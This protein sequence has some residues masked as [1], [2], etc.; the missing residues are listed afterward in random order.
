VEEG[1][2]FIPLLL[3][4]V[5]AF[6]VPLV[7]G[8]IKWLPVVVGEILA[9]VLIGYSGLNLVGESQILEFM[10]D[11]GLAFLMFIAGMEINLNK[12]L[13]IN[14]N[15]PSQQDRKLFLPTLG[16]YLLTVSLAIPGGFLLN[17][18]GL[19]DIFGCL[20]PDPQEARDDQYTRWAV[21]LLFGHA[22]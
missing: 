4:L 7:V 16:V 15:T 8:R 17:R 11:I 19:C 3:I 21:D 13:P 18:L 12:L 22:G 10:G 14:G 2:N 20:A 5:L 6:F 9:G 1:L